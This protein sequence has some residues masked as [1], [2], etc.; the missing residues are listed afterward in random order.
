VLVVSA[1]I[2]AGVIGSL[3]MAQ[4]LA[5]HLNVQVES[6]L[7]RFYR[8]LRNPRFD[9]EALTEALLAGLSQKSGDVVIA[10]DWTEWVNEMRVL[11][12]AV[13]AGTRAIPVAVATHLE[14]TFL[15]SQNAFENDSLL[16]LHALLTRC[17]IRATL[18]ADRG[19]RRASLLRLLTQWEQP[20]VIR[21]ISDVSVLARGRWVRLRNFH[22][23]PGQAV[24]LGV[25]CLGRDRAS[26]IHV[27][28]VGVHAC[29]TAETWW[30]ATNE[31]Y[32]VAH[33]VA[34]YDRRMA[35][36]EQFRDAKG[37]RF[38]L[39]MQWTQFQKEGHVDRVFLLAGAVLF[40]LIAIGR[41]VAQQRPDVR[42]R[43]PEK[44]P[45]QSYFTVALAW[46]LELPHRMRLGI[47]V[48]AEAVPRP[49]YRHFPWIREGLVSPDDLS[50]EA[51]SVGQLNV[52]VGPVQ[53]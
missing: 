8:L 41:I 36:E 4:R 39:Q 37:C 7:N 40:V 29:G 28:V 19:F 26:R 6:A 45:R 1:F 21:L 11:V 53:N 35:V 34:L 2:E 43:H 3:D 30:L 52:E 10:V 32:S 48:V 46:A 9:T 20:F 23:N 16:R 14:S 15:R 17:G 31:E 22:L 51:T 50:L 24:D 44:G 13:V 5:I 27:R 12:A 47:R 25:V 18:L 49:D 42:F 38:G 33:V